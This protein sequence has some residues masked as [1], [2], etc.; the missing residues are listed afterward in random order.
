MENDQ[1]ALRQYQL[2]VEINPSI[3]EKSMNKQ[4]PYSFKL[5]EDNFKRDLIA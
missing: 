2:S 5:L 1:R 4:H 3:G